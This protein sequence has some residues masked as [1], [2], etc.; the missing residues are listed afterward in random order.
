MRH[1][2]G[3]AD[4]DGIWPDNVAAVEAFLACETQW[5]AVPGSKRL[6]FIGLDYAGA[7]AG[8]AAA[9]I[10]VTPPLWSAVR[11]MEMAAREALNEK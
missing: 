3:E 5:R 8:I 6:V 1:A 10:T 4:G 7:T 9:G 11:V 2:I